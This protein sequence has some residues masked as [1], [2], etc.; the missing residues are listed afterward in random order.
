MH[1]QQWRQY[2]SLKIDLTSFISR[3]SI[4]MNLYIMETFKNWMHCEF[5]KTFNYQSSSW[6]A[7][8][9]RRNHISYALCHFIGDKSVFFHAQVWT[10]TNRYYNTSLSPL[11][12]LALDW[13]PK[14]I[15]I[16]SPDPSIMKDLRL[17]SKVFLL[18]IFFICHKR[19]TKIF[20][21]V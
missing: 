1:C 18:I 12:L 19:M 7:L 3:S 13:F 5:K 17:K 20:S 10:T 21:K 11:S 16:R 2:F 15:Y 9:C 8:W 14:L 6:S 4:N